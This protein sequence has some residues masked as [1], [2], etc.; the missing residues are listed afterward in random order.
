MILKNSCQLEHWSNG[1]MGLDCNTLRT[2]VK[3]VLPH[4][5]YVHCAENL[6]KPLATDLGGWWIDGKWQQEPAQTMAGNST[7]I[8]ALIDLL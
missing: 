7:N 2:H 6:T 8:M 4:V 1:A 3:I 5:Y